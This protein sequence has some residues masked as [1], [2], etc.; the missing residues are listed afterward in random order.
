MYRTKYPETHAKRNP[1][2][3]SKLALVSPVKSAGVSDSAS[4]AVA[5]DGST[6]LSILP[7]ISIDVIKTKLLDIRATTE[8]F[9]GLQKFWHKEGRREAKALLQKIEKYEAKGDDR[10]TEDREEIIR[11]YLAIVNKAPKDSVRYQFTSEHK[12][13]S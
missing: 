6:S 5:A 4:F 13:F 7:D 12:S 2:A 10:T 11:D 3:E 1:D 8:G 9:L